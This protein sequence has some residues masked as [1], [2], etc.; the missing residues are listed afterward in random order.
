VASFV[1]IHGAWHGAWCWEKVAAILRERGH[2]V[3]TPDLP[4]HGNDATPRGEVSL[5]A[6]AQATAG[7]L[8]TTREPALL[9]G[10]SMGGMVISAAAELAPERVRG[11]VFLCAIVPANGDCM[12]D[13]M[14]DNVSAI[15]GN[16][17]VVEDSTA[18]V[19]ND[20]VLVRA[21]YHD[22]TEADIELARTHLVPQNSQVMS[23]PVALSADH[24][25]RIP[26]AYIECIEDQAIHIVAQR[27]M[28]RRAG[29]DPIISMNTSHSPFFSV[30]S[31]LADALERA[32]S[33]SAPRAA[34]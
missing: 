2:E 22:C 16:L 1:L 4:G 18:V 32:L 17:A 6:Y 3:I 12:T 14:V 8:E 27:R 10:H 28:A 31:E 5:D 21:F 23:Q 34:T 19:V 26:R 33:A 13:L 25:G 30:P 11:L 29:C 7:V 24:Y 15:N 9:I 20:D